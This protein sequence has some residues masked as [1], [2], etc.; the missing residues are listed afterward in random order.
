ML[1]RILFPVWFWARVD[2]K[3]QFAQDIEG[4]SEAAAFV[5][6]SWRHP[7]CLHASL[8]DL[9]SPSLPWGNTHTRSSSSSHDIPM[10]F[11]KSWA[12]WACHSMQ[13]V[14]TF[15]AGHP[16]HWVAAGESGKFQSA[17]TGFSCPRGSQFNL[18]VSC[19]HGS[20]AH[21]HSSRC[22]SSWS[23]A[24]SGPA[25]GMEQEKAEA[26]YQLPLLHTSSPVV[27]PYCT[28]SFC[29]SEWTLNKTPPNEFPLLSWSLK[30]VGNGPMLPEPVSSHLP[31]QVLPRPSSTWL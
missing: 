25:A 8:A 18:T 26:V 31:L 5:S 28:S 24:T 4:G 19:S 29:L 13:R 20:C 15:P 2:H 9:L 27:H 22:R 1:S 23:S 14:P 6:M 10:G 21:P 17:F 16:Q 3:S 30:H 7:G 11:S 12:Q